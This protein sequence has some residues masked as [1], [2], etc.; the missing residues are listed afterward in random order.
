[1]AIERFARLVLGANLSG[2][3]NADGSITLDVA[4]TGGATLLGYTQFT[5]SV[6][7]NA[8]TAAGADTV[9]SVASVVVPAAT[10]ICV[11]FSAPL[12]T[13]AAASNIR[14]SLWQ[15]STDLGAITNSLGSGTQNAPVYARRYLTPGAGTYTYT[16]KVYSNGGSAGGTVF[17]GA[18]GAGTMMPGYIR[19]TSGS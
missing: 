4:A 18:G 12:I 6:T 8:T 1:M 9:V 16:I 7:Q 5:S 17:A 3:D 19:V 15:G 2:T 11:E 14:C 13:S 10:L